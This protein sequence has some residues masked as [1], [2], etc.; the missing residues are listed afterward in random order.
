MPYKD[1]Q[2][3][4]EYKR[5]WNKKYY[6]NHKQEELARVKKR[7][8]QLR[9]W[10]NGYKK[11]LTCSKCGENHPACL[12]FHHLDEKKK[13]FIISEAIEKR[14]YSKEKMLLEISKCIVLC[15]N[16]HKKLHSN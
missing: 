3:I 12:E 13:S 2:K 16:C 7:K 11:T 4:I 15:A 8:K 5:R 14:G 10:F 6:E 9:K 1:R